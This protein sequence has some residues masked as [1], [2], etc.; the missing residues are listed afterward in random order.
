M[1]EKVEKE[2]LL[3]LHQ[4]LARITGEIG[5]V[6]KD[7][8]NSEQNFKFI[9]YAAIAGKLRTL[10]AKYGVVIVPRMQR[11]SK[12]SRSEITSKY[13]KKGQYVLID[14]Y[15]EVI[16]ADDPSDHFNVHWTGEAADYGDKATNKAATSA[17]KY[18]LMRQFN[19]SEKGE[20]NDTETPEVVL[21]PKAPVKPSPEQGL[22]GRRQHLAGLLKKLGIHNDDLDDFF[23]N[24]LGQDRPSTLGD[25]NKAIKFAEERLADEEDR[26]KELEAR[27]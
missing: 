6:A 7:G 3:N 14:M 26:A 22:N 27:V 13:G 24:A 15:F 2:E 25:V 17:L 23:Q 12:Q 8:N 11:A 19:I 4:K 9:E 10:F 18:Y 20:D 16:N 21:V 5:V 1:T